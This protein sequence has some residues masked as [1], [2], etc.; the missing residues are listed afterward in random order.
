MILFL[1]FSHTVDSQQGYSDYV[2]NGKEK[3]QI[4]NLHAMLQLFTNYFVIIP[5]I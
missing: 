2:F 3:F 5:Y 4:I 1:A